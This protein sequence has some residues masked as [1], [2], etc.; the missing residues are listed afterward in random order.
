MMPDFDDKDLAIITIGIIALA[1]IIVTAFRTDLGAGDII[2]YAIT[3]IG[4]IATGRALER[5]KIAKET[6]KDV[7]ADNPS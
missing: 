7:D 6:K 4:S 5:A 1:S 2:G 3:A